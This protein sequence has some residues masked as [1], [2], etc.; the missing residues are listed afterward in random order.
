MTCKI[1]YILKTKPLNYIR[2]SFLFSL[3]AIILLSV[4]PKNLLSQDEPE[5]F[6]TS[7]F[8]DV[9]RL[10]GTEI[11]SVIGNDKL[12]LSVS[13]LFSFLRI[14]NTAT[15]NFESISGFIIDEKN[16]YV[17][18]RL[19]NLIKYGD[20]TYYLE[21]GDLI[22]TETGLFLKSNY[23]GEIFDLDC[24]FNFRNL[25]VKL[26]T[27]LDLP[28]IREMRL[29][30]MRNNVKQ[31]EGEVQA[32]TNIKRSY[33]AFSFGMFDWSINSAQRIDQLSNT[34]I[35]LG[36][37]S[38]L[39]GGEANVV[40]NYNTAGEFKEKQQFYQ[41]RL[42]NNDFKV[43]KQVLVGK[44]NPYSTSSIFD[45]LIGIQ[46]T[47]TPTSYRRSYGS[48][49]LSDY[50]KPGWTVELYVNN[51][52][53][54]YQVADASGFFTFNVPLVYGNTQVTLKYYGPWG[55]ERTSER[56]IN[57]PFSFV[58]KNELEYRI[59]GGVIED[60]V[61]SKYSRGELNYGL[62]RYLTVG[63][64]VEYLSS[65]TSGNFMPFLNTT[66]SLGGRLLFA[67]NYTHGVQA[68]GVVS[69]S[70]KSGLQF[71]AEYINYVEGQTAINYNYSE[72]RKASVTW[73]IRT[74][75]FS[76]LT[77]FSFN[78][79]ILPS[80]QYTNA[81]FLISGNVFGVG[82]NLTTF[83]IFSEN[84]KPYIYSNLSLAFKV[85]RDAYVRPQLQ[86]DFTNS[87]FISAKIEI[88]KRVFRIAYLTASYEENISSNIR[89]F[90]IG[91]RFDL[92][93]AQASF[94]SR[95]GTAGVT[96]FETAR[97]SLQ[98][99]PNAGYVNATNRT[100]VGMGGII[101]IPFLDLNNNGK[102]DKN[103]SKVMGL[104]LRV[105]GGNMQQ[106]EKDTI[107]VVSQLEAYVNY[108]I[109]M[110]LSNFD[111]ISW[112]L[113]V[114][115]MN[116]TV[117]PN[118]M[119]TIEV[120]VTVAGEATG[121]IELKTDKGTQGLGRITVNFYDKY[122]KLVASTLS[123]GDG[124][125]S[126]LGLSPGYYTAAVDS[127]QLKRLNMEVSPKVLTFKISPSI[128]GDYVEDLNFTIV[129]TDSD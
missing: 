39:F 60:S 94:Y 51:T 50:T 80:T 85:F 15:S 69:Y 11:P 77:K 67:G 114:K 109:E 118:Q 38:V 125:F 44:L 66:L 31:L 32:D 110:R 112:Q 113:K 72:V 107:I 47:N 57:I 104:E 129:K 73:P 111:N 88:E 24:S 17:I 89:N 68:K 9:Y 71:N 10:G 48:Y 81:E 87:K 34:R 58:P 95:V 36:I 78:Q 126:Y 106:R 124:Y 127:E 41:W 86:Y 45:P 105:R 21:P 54:D 8:L 119:R 64:G 1:A 5:F 61:W 4:L 3:L 96:F 100:N 62:G 53:V 74:S 56:D 97:G 19:N 40:L 120:P 82:T 14:K 13:D 91:V 7:I 52:L 102:Y 117:N 12:F 121:M 70:F 49:V 92:S 65:V 25:S 99:A 115:T 33:P 16:T 55:E 43:V 101:I 35:N 2:F 22:R 123:E 108:F 76:L 116:V 90:Q 84:P 63:G 103:E 20:K 128:D 79:Y 37:G 28:A 46:L 27:T 98:F 18:D 75:D 59:T 42:A 122:N 23:F 83:A 6:E 26:V 93:F 29:E 30:N